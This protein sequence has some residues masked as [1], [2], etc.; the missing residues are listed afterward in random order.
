LRY[1]RVPADRIGVLIGPEGETKK[2]LER[3]LEVKM[4]IDSAENEVQIDDTGAKDPVAPLKAEDIVKAIARGFS[5][6]HAMKLLAEDMYL[7]VFDM[8][9]YVGKDKQGVRRVAARVIGSEGRTRRI[10]E[11]LSGC[12]V[13]V[14]GHTVALIG[15]AEPLVVAKEA[16]E[17]LLTGSEHAAVYHHLE[18]WRRQLKRARLEF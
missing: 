2:M 17:M 13:S 9:D 7:E 8:H 4:T 16:V 11:D 6:E 5:P 18:N 14:Y 3:R 10:I 15:E 1:V 12:L